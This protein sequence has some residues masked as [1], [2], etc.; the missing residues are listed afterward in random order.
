MASLT[1]ETWQC[2]ACGKESVTKLQCCGGCKSV[3]YCDAK[4]QQQH[5]NAGHKSK[6]KE[7]K[8][9]KGTKKFETRTKKGQL[10]H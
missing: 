3:Y 1:V 8:F 2:D 6:C 5:W 4:C 7:M 10:K 9:E